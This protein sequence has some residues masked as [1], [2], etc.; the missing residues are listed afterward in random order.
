MPAFASSEVSGPK[1]IG[2]L[3][4]LMDIVSCSRW[5]RFTAA[6]LFDA[7][8]AARGVG[9]GNDMKA[10]TMF[11]TP[12]AQYAVEVEAPACQMEFAGSQAE[13]VGK[14]TIVIRITVPQ[15][16]RDEHRGHQRSKAK[17][18]VVELHVWR[19][20]LPPDPCHC[21]LRRE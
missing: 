13:L 3:S 2:A 12:M 9:N 20:I 10:T 5:L 18:S 6:D 7:A 11:V 15:L 17:S 4:A 21:G 1:G 8:P 19:N 16:C 14:L